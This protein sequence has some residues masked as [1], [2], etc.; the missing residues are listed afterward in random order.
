MY[1]VITILYMKL[2][3]K[4]CRKQSNKS[5]TIALANYTD[6]IQ[7]LQLVNSNK[8]PNTIHIIDGFES[9]GLLTAYVINIINNSI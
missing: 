3:D 2:K 4:L 8:K 6:Q 1:L 7:I 9:L 5:K